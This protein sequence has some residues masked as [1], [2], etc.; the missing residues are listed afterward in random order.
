MA[1]YYP[2]F[3]TAFTDWQTLYP[4]YQSDMA[5]VK[6]RLIAAQTA[7]F[8]AA[9]FTALRLAVQY[10]FFCV[11]YIAGDDLNTWEEGMYNNLMY[12]AGKGGVDMQGIIDAMMDAEF[13]QLKHFIGIEDAYRAAIWDQPFEA[14]FYADLVRNWR[15]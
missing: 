12:Y 10:L 3:D 8:T 2:D 14:E 5:T 4:S 11:K 1:W 13:A 7:G 6:S 9:G 15:T